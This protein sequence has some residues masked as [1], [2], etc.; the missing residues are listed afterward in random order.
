MT[1][2]LARIYFRAQPVS[3]TEN[4]KAKFVVVENVGSTTFRSE[5]LVSAKKRDFHLP[6]PIGR[7]AMFSEEEKMVRI[8]TKNFGFSI[9]PQP[10][11][12]VQWLTR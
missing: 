8:I 12:V 10:T 6:Y 5:A 11:F 2:I 1:D 7:K 4:R 9:H 3:E